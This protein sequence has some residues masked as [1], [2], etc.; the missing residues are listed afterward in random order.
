MRN[1]NA[2]RRSTSGCT[3][4]RWAPTATERGADHRARRGPVPVRQCTASA[5]STCSAGLFTVQIGYSYGEELGQ[6]ALEQMRS[7]SRTTRT[8]RSRTRLRS[9]SPPSWPSWRPPAINRAFFV[10]GGS[11]AVESAMEAGPPVPRRQRRAH[12]AQGHR[13][14]D[15][16]PRHHVG[17][18]SLTGITGDPHAVRAARSTASATSRTPT[19]TA[20]STAPDAQD[21]RSRAPTRW[22]RRSSS[23]APRPSRW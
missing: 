12:A 3:S 2:R 9:S 20:A 10:S 23:R 15:R 8:G 16:L 1:C 4:P 21:A 11:E 22:P 5:T 6:A 17:A 18:L 19:A 7:S 14:Q 13:A